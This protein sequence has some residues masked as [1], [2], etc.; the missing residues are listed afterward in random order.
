MNIESVSAWEKSRYPT[1][2]IWGNF[3]NKV[4]QHLL[5]RSRKYI[6]K[7]IYLITVHWSIGRHARRV[8]T[9]DRSCPGCGICA[10]ETDLEHVWCLCPALAWYRLEYLGHYS[11][12]FLTLREVSNK[13][14]LAF[15]DRIKWF[16][17][18][19]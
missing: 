11:P 16:D 19:S 3:D 13:D 1:K 17:K 7:V 2:Y 9:G 4:S 5:E 10:L 14:I 15:I 12:S 8:G 6:R 18:T